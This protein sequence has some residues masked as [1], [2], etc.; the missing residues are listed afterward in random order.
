MCPECNQP[1]YIETKVL[2]EG[3]HVYCESCG[4]DLTEIAKPVPEYCKF[5]GETCAVP[6]GKAKRASDLGLQKCGFLTRVS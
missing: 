2:M 3:T 5:T 4:T 1:Y 6:C